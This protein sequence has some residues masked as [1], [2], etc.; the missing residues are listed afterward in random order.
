MSLYPLIRLNFFSA[1]RRAATAHRC[2]MPPSLHR[3]T[4]PVTVR[5]TEKHDSI[6]LVEHSVFLS[7]PVIPIRCT[8]NVFSSPSFR[9]AAALGFNRSRYFSVSSNDCFA[10]SYVSYRRRIVLKKCCQNWVI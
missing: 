8:V 1:R 3:F 2:T 6:G 5:V 4:R 9:L 7:K 10:C